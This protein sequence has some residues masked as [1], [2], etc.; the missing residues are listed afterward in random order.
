MVSVLFDW[1]EASS[2]P[3][4]KGVRWGADGTWSSSG[5]YL[6][7]LFFILFIND[8]PLHV[9]SHVDLCL[10]LSLNI[11]ANK[12]RHW[13]DS[14]K[15][16]INESKSKVFTI[17][18]KRLASKINDERVVIVEDNRLIN[19]K[20]AA[21][22]GLTIDSSPSFDCHVENLRNELV[23]RI[24][25]LSKIRTFLSLEQGVLFYNAIIRPVMSYGDVIWS[26]CDMEPL[27]RV[28]KLQKRA[29]RVILY[30][31]RLAPS[32]T[33]FNKLGWI[34]FYEQSKINKFAIFHK[35]V[36]GSLPNYLNEHLTINNSQH[37]RS[38]RYANYNSICPYY[39]RETGGR[40]FAV[41]ATRL[42]NNVPLNIRKSDSV[43]SLK[44]HLFKT[45]FAEKQHLN[46]FRI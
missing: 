45:I 26:S 10:K 30:A 29:A 4:W 16:Q 19:L 37:N 39:K 9:S 43:K 22:L 36:N 20:S 41:S 17:T 3:G 18:G 32:M 40:S 31:N 25:I 15:L 44:T 27:Y 35:R 38:K 14:N 33:L 7:P 23:S 5:Q 24:G 11:S 42:W 46:H 6:G 2:S 34:P 1:K 12:I 21:Y 8:L 28:L 13:V